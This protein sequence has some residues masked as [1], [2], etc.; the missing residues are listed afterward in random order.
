[1]MPV[2]ETHD[3]YHHLDEHQKETNHDGNYYCHYDDDFSRNRII[4][5]LESVGSR[6]QK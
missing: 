6:E 5:G 3:D 4:P 1:M 2:L